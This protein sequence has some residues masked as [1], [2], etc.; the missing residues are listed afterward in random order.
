MTVGELI[1]KLEQY[2]PRTK[3]II[4]HDPEVGWY[5]AIEVEEVRE[6]RT[7][8]INIQSSNES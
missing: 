1:K 4:D 6:K 3:V 8:F 2:S 5:D 7:K